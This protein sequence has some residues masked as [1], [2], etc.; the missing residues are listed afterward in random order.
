MKDKL[1]QRVSLAVEPEEALAQVS[2]RKRRAPLQ[3]QAV[4]VL[5][6]MGEVSAKELCYFTGASMTTLRS[7]EKQG[8]LTLRKQ[9][10]FRR[11]PSGGGAECPGSQPCGPQ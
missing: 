4:K 6:E 11:P 1:E 7:L 2:G 5:G 3:Y 8:L 9:E 10:V